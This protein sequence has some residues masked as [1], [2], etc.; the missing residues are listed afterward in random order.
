MSVT[1]QVKALEGRWEAFAGKVTGRLEEIL[2]EAGSGFDE[3]IAT[4]ALDPAPLSGALTEFE[5]RLRALVKKVDESFE[6]LDQET[7]NLMD[8]AD[9]PDVALVG[10]LRD[11]LIR[12]RSA[13]ADAIEG[14]G[15]ALSVKKAADAA[16]ALSALAQAEMEKAGGGRKCSSCGGPIKP[17]VLTEPSNVTCAHCKAVNTVHPGAAPALYFGGAALHALATEAA[18]PQDAARRAAEKRFH[19]Y[20]H[21]TDDDARRYEEAE[22]TY[23]R[24]YCQA[25]GM[26]KPEWT[27]DRLEAAAQAKLG[28]LRAN[29]KRDCRERNGVTAGMKLAS[30]GDRA[31]VGRWL[32]TTDSRISLD[33]LLIAAHEHGDKKAT[34]LLLD[35]AWKKE[36]SDE[37]QASW[38][39]EKLKELDTD[40]A[41]R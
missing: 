24:V 10:K 19:W 20:R 8:A 5:A 34:D 37:P 35:L 23:W 27:P 1:E 3:I 4:E 26:H 9:G 31:G 6:K 25:L 13:L 29:F 40:L 12:K 11:G 36:G 21:P 38:K 39:A 41:R 16:R 30:A 14:R 17:A 18:L 32:E 15:Q 33:E 22:L 2:A 28:W 7:D